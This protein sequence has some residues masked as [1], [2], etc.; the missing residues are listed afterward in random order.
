MKWM[1]ETA[2]DSIA[3][4]AITLLKAIRTVTKVAKPSG[5]KVDVVVDNT[6]QP[7]YATFSSKKVLCVRYRGSKQRY[8][9][10]EKIVAAI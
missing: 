3:A 1:G 5:I 6:L 8:K 10:I 4:C 2:R 7:S 9:G